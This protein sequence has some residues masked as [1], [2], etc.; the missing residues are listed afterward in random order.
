[1]TIIVWML[2]NSIH[3]NKICNN[4]L[5]GVCHSYPKI[6]W[7][8]QQE[9]DF[10]WDCACECVC[11]VKN[12]VI[13]HYHT[14]FGVT[15]RWQLLS[16]EEEQKVSTAYVKRRSFCPPPLATNWR[17]PRLVKDPHCSIWETCFHTRGHDTAAVRARGWMYLKCHYSLLFSHEAT[18]SGT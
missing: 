13:S 12:G 4:V 15:E 16:M 2:T 10:F 7:R 5:T 6:N 9:G 8:A 11:S 3:T 17:R 14:V 18:T 1:M